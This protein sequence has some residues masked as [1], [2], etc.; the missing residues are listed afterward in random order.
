MDCLEFRR[1]LGSDPRLPD[2][3][4][5]EHAETCASCADARSRAVAFETRLAGALA[6]PLPD[7]LADRILLAQLTST[8]SR[9]RSRRQ[10]LGWFALAAAASVAL[11]VGLVRMNASVVLPDLVAAHVTG[12]ER[13]ALDLRAPLP[14]ATV[15][16]AFADRGVKL[17]SVP[18]DIAYVHKCPI[19]RYK[20]VHMVMP[21][22]GHPVS[23]VYVVDH[24]AGASEDFRRDGLAGREVPVAKGTLVM[25]AQDAS[26]FDAIEQAWR[27][28]IEGSPEVAAGSR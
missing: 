21:E 24:R 27:G 8:R 9:E 26:R 16:K 20:S 28:A 11:V 12:E 5:R 3:A 6:V 10:R 18:D 4:A 14:A 1:R 13:A 19:G 23:V 22:G 17:A 15:E 7:G 25:L 2:R